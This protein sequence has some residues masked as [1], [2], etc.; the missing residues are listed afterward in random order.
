VPL[1]ISSI[2]YATQ[3]HQYNLHLFG[4]GLTYTRVEIGEDGAGNTFAAAGLGE[5]GLVKAAGADLVTD[6]GVES[7]IGPKA[8]LEKVPAFVMAKVN[9]CDHA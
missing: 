8:M 1:R 5:E 2:G 4:A 6:I 7:A 9:M 3:N